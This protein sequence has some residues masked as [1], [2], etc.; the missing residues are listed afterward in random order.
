MRFP[1]PTRRG[2]LRRLALLAVVFA[3][4]GAATRIEKQRL[5]EVLPGG[6]RST[7]IVDEVRLLG[8]VRELSAPAMEG[9]RT[10]SEGN[11]RAR[12][13]VVQRLREEGA[14]PLG[15]AY[16]HPFDFTH[17]SVRAIWRRDRP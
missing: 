15:G 4:F 3:W 7:S 17:T 10:G 1:R 14:M 5:A 12:A 16:E 6:S 8:D 11:A 13:Y 2:L 9:R